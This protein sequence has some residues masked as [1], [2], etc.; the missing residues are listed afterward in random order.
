MKHIGEEQGTA[1]LTLE[2]VGQA[3]ILQVFPTH[4][5]KQTLH[6]VNT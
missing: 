1:S 5:T 6:S 2:E 3:A 4:Y